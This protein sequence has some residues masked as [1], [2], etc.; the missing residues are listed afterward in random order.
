MDIRQEGYKIPKIQYE[1]YYHCNNDSKLSIL[2]INICKDIDID[3]YLPVTLNGKLEQYDPNSDFYNDI[4][5]TF[6]SENGT[7]LTLSTR[8]K[9]Y[10]NNNL[11]VCEE[12][13]YISEYNETTQKAKC[14]CKTKTDFI[15]KLSENILNK[16][17]LYKSFTDFNNIFNI[18]ILKCT[19]LI[20]TLKAFK[21]NYA[22][23]ILLVIIILYIICLIIFVFKSYNNDIKFYINIII[24]FTLFPIKIIYIIRKNKRQE[25]KSI[26]NLN[27]NNINNTINLNNNKS[28]NNYN[29][30]KKY[31]K[32]KKFNKKKDS[33]T[34]NLIVIKP[35]IYNIFIKLKKK[36][37]KQNL[38]SN[39]IKKGEF[40]NTKRRNLDNNIFDKIKIEERTNEKLIKKYD[41]L[42]EFKNLPESQIYDLHIK[43]YKK[44]DM[45]LN[46]SS[47]KFALKFD[48]RTFVQF[49]ISLVKCNHLLFFS[50]IPKFDF[51]SKIIKIYLFFLNF[52]TYFFINALFFTDNTISDGFNLITNL[53]QT[54]YSSII[55]AVINEII[56]FLA[57]TENSFINYRNKAKKATIIK[58]AL[59]LLRNFKIKFVIFFI[60]NLILLGC[61][62]IYLSCF[63][64]VYH[65][66][67]LHLI[68]DTIISF[69]TSFISPMVLYLVPGIFRIPSLK[70]K[71]RKCLYGINQILQLL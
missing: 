5:N 46:N 40:I 22:N 37:N 50:F 25:T 4:C 32:N 17:E 53:P 18:K 3:I 6:T 20:F 61:F 36:S 8:K 29:Y 15:Y 30:R 13:C 69:G 12:K 58:S 34:Q 70:G 7:D 2:D 10:I 47:Y 59:D 21:E 67:Q 45:E 39:P 14:S 41:F 16:E 48:K 68:K 11:A 23:I 65:N 57:L 62:W 28:N 52:A 19:K 1:V 54:I 64:A 27:K 66:T 44:T 24:Y 51:N 56:K 43:I 49:Y 42:N 9:N 26:I 60:L 35:P 71:N 38:L 55:S 31:L 63:S 33:K